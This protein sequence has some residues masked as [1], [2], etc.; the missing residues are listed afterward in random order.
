MRSESKVILLKS[1][2]RLIIYDI[3]K[4]KVCDSLN[5][6]N[7]LEEDTLEHVVDFIYHKKTRYLYVLTSHKFLH[8]IKLS[9]SE[10][11]FSDKKNYSWKLRTKDLTRGTGLKNLKSKDVQLCTLAVNYS[12]KQ[13]MLSGFFEQEV[14]LSGQKE[15]YSS[16]ASRRRRVQTVSCN[17]MIALEFSHSKKE[18]DRMI[19]KTFESNTQ[20]AQ[21][22]KNGRES[23]A[24]TVK[25]DAFR[26]LK[27][28]QI[29]SDNSQGYKEVLIAAKIQN[30]AITGYEISFRNKSVTEIVKERKLSSEM[31]LYAT[32]VQK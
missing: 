15:N 13:I 19:F 8:I 16:R 30:L 10:S 1:S 14:I 22:L 3:E 9:K 4:F 20:L 32:R 23:E 18:V 11:A 24:V 25:E 29:K 5:F 31:M 27:F 28:I 26:Y 12:G 6:D 7:E 21:I 2:S 17:L